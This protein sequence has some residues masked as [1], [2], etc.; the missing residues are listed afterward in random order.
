MKRRLGFI[1]LALFVIAGGVALPHLLPAPPLPRDYGAAVHFRDGTLMRLYATHTGRR[2]YY[3][4]LERIDPLLV[5]ATLVCEDKRFYHHP[6]VDPLSIIRAAWQNLKAGH[7]VSGGSTITLQLVRLLR[8]G[9][10]T[11][12]RKALEAVWALGMEARLSKR[13]I[14]E[15][16]FNLAPYGGNLEGVGAASLAYFGKLPTSLAPDEIAFLISLPQAPIRART[17]DKRARD[18][19]IERMRTA[20][21]ITGSEALKARQAPIPRHLHP[22][23]FKAP[24]AAD[25]LHLEYPGMSHIQTTLSPEIQAL[26]E[27]VIRRHAG[28]ILNLGAS[29]AAVVIMSNRDRR[30]R[31]L[32]GSLDY[33]NR[34]FQGQVRGF[35]A[36][37]STG[38]TLKPFLYALALQRGTITPVTRLEDRPR[39]FGAF[40]PVDFSPRFMGMVPAKTAL[41]RSL[42]LPFINLLREIRLKAFLKFMEMAG[43]HWSKNPGLTAVTGGMETSLLSLTNFYVT[44]AREG[45]H[46]PPRILTSDPLRE[47]P[48]LNPGAA[49]LTL[50]ALLCAS[51]GM[52]GPGF[53]LAWKTGTSFGQRDAW[54]L[55]V[56]PQYTVG[57]W[58]GNF[59]GQGVYGLTGATAAL[60]I[61]FDLMKALGSRPAKFHCPSDSLTWIHVCPDSGLPV[62]AY[63]PRS[64]LSPFPKGAPLPHRCSWHRPFIME[65]G[66]GFRACPWKTY[67]PDSLERRV[68]LI[69]PGHAPP[70]FSPACSV[71]DPSGE[72]RIL[73][74]AAGTL[75]LLSPR[76]AF[77]RGLPLK[78][79]TDLPNGR[80]YW[81]VNGKLVA[82]SQSGAVIFVT[83][84][85]GRVDI[86]VMDEEGRWNQVT[87]WVD[88]VASGRT[89][90]TCGQGK[91]SILNS[92]PKT[93]ALYCDEAF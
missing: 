65:R 53:D 41:A 44:L 28:R 79:V 47:K 85:L 34:E 15:Y 78:G 88:Y 12:W 3:L 90:K 45:R 75:Y 57:V 68:L 60:P 81:F 10:R 51:H 4:P 32:V 2:R 30:V 8:P 87:S 66:R 24:H 46:G 17:H 74:P 23:P 1:L 37:R 48:L 59:N 93:R 84:P 70:P 58:V 40:R 77:S 21:L 72:I 52:P 63:C 73:S 20:G 62:S 42:N 35:E 91:S 16:Y 89:G 69:V 38:S 86:R 19:V 36:V 6:G 29:A 76:G 22:F 13:Q 71:E 43:F 54:A 80:L 5:K 14:L 55:G 64:A 11:F 92:R 26:A 7:V 49:Y 33:W 56:S 25:Y 50:Q 67:P 83:P 82:K 18:R 39:A 61:T 31:A 27:E 9:P